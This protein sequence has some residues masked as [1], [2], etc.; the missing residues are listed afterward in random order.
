MFIIAGPT[1]EDFDFKIFMTVFDF[2]SSGH[3]KCD[4]WAIN[5][6]DETVKN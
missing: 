6:Q 3:V 4:S 2:S 5:P 1:E